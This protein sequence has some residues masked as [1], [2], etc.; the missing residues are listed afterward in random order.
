MGFL[1]LEIFHLE[2]DNSLTL[3]EDRGL[4]VSAFGR[5]EVPG[6]LRFSQKAQSPLQFKLKALS[7]RLYESIKV[8]FMGNVGSHALV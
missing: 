8:G 1:S 5:G 2:A 6:L 4:M 3:K 7:D